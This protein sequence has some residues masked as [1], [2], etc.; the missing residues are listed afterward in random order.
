MT[1]VRNGVLGRIK[2][3]GVAD[4]VVGTVPGG[5]TWLLKTVHVVNYGAAAD[6]V[7]LYMLSADGVFQGILEEIDVQSNKGATWSG[8]TCLQPGDQLR[9]N[10]TEST[11]VWAA[12]AELPGTIV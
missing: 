12:G 6:V 7:V 4:A 1:G 9:V 2:T 10:V 5:F 11:S 3:E 8:W